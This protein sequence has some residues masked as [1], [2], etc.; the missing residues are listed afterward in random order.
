MSKP[1]P[2]CALL[3][4]LTLLASG[5][6]LMDEEAVKQSGSLLEAAAPSPESVTMEIIWARFPAG[7][8]ALNEAVWQD[9][10]ETRLPPAVRDRL[11]ENGFRVG[12]IAGALPD[13]IASA[14]RHG[15]SP[16]EQVKMGEAMPLSELAK[17]P[18]VHGRVRR[19]R[20]DQ[21]SE[22]QA[23]EVFPEV[24]LL[25]C[26]GQELTGKTFQQAQAIY[27]LRVDPQPDRT[28]I[29]ELTPE[30]HHGQPRLR[31]TGADGMG[32]R[33][34]SMREHEVFDRMRMTVRLAPGEILVLMNLPNSGSRLGHYF[35]TVD[36]A[37]GLQ[38]K[39]ILLRL[40]EVPPSDT[41]A[42]GAK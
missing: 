9:I 5:C 3:S 30:L 42:F 10:D 35:H 6:R 17:E 12:V 41:F 37:D 16:D 20:R 38:Q 15:E 21:R 4:L 18:I 28:T 14:I 29:V 36:S 40:A 13:T 11:T 32:L 25:L 24:P 33:Q 1:H 8:R 22:I 39:L 7:D 2:L 31:Y 34:A 26:G 19:V 23:S 27:A